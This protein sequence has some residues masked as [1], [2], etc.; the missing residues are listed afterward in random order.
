MRGPLRATPTFFFFAGSKAKKKKADKRG[1]K[2]PKMVPSTPETAGR[3]TTNAT[4][5]AL[6]GVTRRLVPL[7]A[8]AGVHLAP[9]DNRVLIGL[10]VLAGMGLAFGGIGAWYFWSKRAKRGR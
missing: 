2:D 5:P 9:A 6:V 4:S 7:E 1:K 8:V 10:G 3:A